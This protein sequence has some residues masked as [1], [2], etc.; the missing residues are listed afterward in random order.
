MT[1]AETAPHPIPTFAPVFNRLL[2]PLL[3]SPL[4]RVISGRLLVLSF[5]GRKSG[6]RYTV[7]ISYVAHEGRLLIGT[8]Q[9]WSKNLAGGTPVE[10]R[11]RGKD[12]TGTAA[13]SPAR[14]RS[15]PSIRSSWPKTP[16]TAASWTSSTA[17]TAGRTRTA[18]VR[19]CG[20]ARS[21]FASRWTTSSPLAVAN[22]PPR[23]QRTHTR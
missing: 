11:L 14:P 1:D 2:G 17:M 4:H 20:G 6:K 7:P 9:P 15:P 16:R 22:P 19:L 23:R 12:R 10:V 13:S 5:S 8:Q 3:R 18:C 21:W